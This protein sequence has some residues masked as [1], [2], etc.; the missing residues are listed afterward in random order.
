MDT[1]TITYA[2]YVAVSAALT[3]F[4]A[5]LLYRNGG[6]FLVKAF[7][8]DEETAAAVNHL[9]VVG[10]WLIN[11]GYIAL[12]LRIDGDVTTARAAF[13]ALAGKLGAVTLGLG[14]LHFSNLVVL[15]RLRRG[16]KL[17]QEPQYLQRPMVP[18]SYAPVPP[19]PAR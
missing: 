8:G 18:V 13:E 14:V 9:L 7:D 19:A 10:F 17:P 16:R 11:V 3:F 12:V 5:R 6:S 2:V 1:I 4:V 15:A